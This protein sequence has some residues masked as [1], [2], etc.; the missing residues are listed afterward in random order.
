MDGQDT[1]LASGYSGCCC[2]FP[3]QASVPVPLKFFL[4]ATMI[5]SY[6][7]GSRLLDCRSIASHE[8][9]DC[10]LDSPAYASPAVGQPFPGLS[11][12][13]IR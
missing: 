3:G 10:T 9:A 1:L 7:R 4:C 2:S 8:A 6:Y 13:R 5:P 12:A 11:Q